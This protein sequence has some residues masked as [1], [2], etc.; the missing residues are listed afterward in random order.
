MTADCRP[1]SN[2][3]GLDD[4]TAKGITGLSPDSQPDSKSS[5]WG[6][7]KPHVEEKVSSAPNV[8][9]GGQPSAAQLDNRSVLYVGEKLMPKLVTAESCV[10]E[11]I[12]DPRSNDNLEGQVCHPDQM[13]SLL[14]TTPHKQKSNITRNK[15]HGLLPQVDVSKPVATPVPPDVDMSP[16]KPKDHQVDADIVDLVKK[17]QN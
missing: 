15:N 7:I 1:H 6:V 13:K 4:E 3:R 16:C 17:L 14:L 8:D 12:P 5:Q 10:G 2:G 9:Q 11:G